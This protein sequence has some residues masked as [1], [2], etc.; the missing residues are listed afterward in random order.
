MPRREA[1]YIRVMTKNIN[2]APALVL[3]STGADYVLAVTVGEIAEGARDCA[4]CGEPANAS[5]TYSRNEPIEGDERDYADVCLR[6]IVP[7]VDSI[8]YLNV[9]VPIEV[10]VDRAATSRPF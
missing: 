3:S 1:G 7:F 5:V 4:H 8:D 2:S 10:E 9:A 6:C